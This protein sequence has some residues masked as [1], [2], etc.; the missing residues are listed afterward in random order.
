MKDYKTF[1][2]ERKNLD[3]EL[4]NIGYS[5][6]EIKELNNLSTKG[7]L[8][9][10]LNSE[11][12][13]FTFG[14]LKAIYLDSLEYKKLDDIKS[15]TYKM[16]VRLTPMALAPFSTLI[17]YIGMILGSTRAV[18]KILEPIIKDPG[19]SYPEFLKK[20]IKKCVDLSEGELNNSDKLKIAFV[21]SDG[22]VDMLKEDIIYQ[23]SY[24]LS[25]KMS[26]E[27]PNTVVP[28]YYI[29]NE[30]RGYLNNTFL[31]EPKLEMKF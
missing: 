23:F 14:I 15:G 8:G 21:V 6:D 28:D 1:I 19:N 26:I 12:K 7:E 16:L 29:E 13:D 25:E 4:R 11:G 31:L 20:F 27:D 17:S 24:Y 18:N 2:T 9:K 30:L 3:N 10:Y 5:D 22:L